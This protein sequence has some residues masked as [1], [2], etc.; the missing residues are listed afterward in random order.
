MV[1]S[2]VTRITRGSS[3]SKLKAL[4]QKTQTKI[5]SKEEEEQVAKEKKDRLDDIKKKYNKV[6]RTRS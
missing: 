2:T 4:D 6:A 3:L 1:G 5:L